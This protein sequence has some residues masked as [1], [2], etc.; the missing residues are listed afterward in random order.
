MDNKEYYIIL[1]ASKINI[2]L[3]VKIPS[4]IRKIKSF[5]GQLFR[6]K[7]IVEIKEWQNSQA[8]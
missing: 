6:I 8:I 1:K 3:K 2:K 4:L 5:Q 7:I